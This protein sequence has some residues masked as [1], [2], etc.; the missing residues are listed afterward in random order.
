MFFLFFWLR[1]LPEYYFLAHYFFILLYYFLYHFSIL[2]FGILLLLFFFLCSIIS[3]THT[4]VVPKFLCAVFNPFL[5]IEF[6]I[7]KEIQ[8]YR[9]VE[10]V[11]GTPYFL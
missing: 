9:L 6:G 3:G 11:Q 8:R 2:F 7:G 10:N 5:T 4:K 1:K